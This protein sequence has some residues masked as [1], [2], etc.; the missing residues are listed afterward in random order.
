M[1]IL[2]ISLSWLADR[3]RLQRALDQMVRYEEMRQEKVEELDAEFRYA[4]KVNEELRG[5]LKWFGDELRTKGSLRYSDAFPRS[6]RRK[7]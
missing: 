6:N 2:A 1:V 3:S 5:E 7:H 4:L